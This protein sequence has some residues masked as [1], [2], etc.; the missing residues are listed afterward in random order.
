[1]TLDFQTNPSKVDS[2]IRE[3]YSAHPGVLLEDAE[4]DVFRAE[5]GAVK[6]HNLRI[7][8]PHGLA[9]LFRKTQEHLESPP[10]AGVADPNCQRLLVRKQ[11]K[12][13]KLDAPEN[14]PERAVVVNHSRDANGAADVTFRVE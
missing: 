7:G 6:S 9:S 4:E 5:I 13:S 3:D 14:V 12:Q 10:P 8:R 11:R 1:E 2:P